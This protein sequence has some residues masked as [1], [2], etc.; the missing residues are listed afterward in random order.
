MKQHAMSAA[1]A[2]VIAAAVALAVGQLTPRLPLTQIVHS[3]NASK[4]AW[5]DLSDAEKAALT[6]ELAWLRGSKVLVL[7][8]GA[9]CEDLQTDIDD[10]LEDAG[11]DS[12]RDKP[13]AP[14][15]YGLA[16]WAAP[17]D[18][19]G[20][21][22]AA[23]LRSVTDGRLDAKVD[24]DARAQDPIIAIGKMPRALRWSLSK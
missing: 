24:R 1:I 16:V 5:P 20:E 6:A 9:E 15:A 3:I 4:Y 10:A 11:V 23:S 8:G 7:C 13:Y 2:A 19:R 14:L 18:V 17:G 22:L 21:R 12:T